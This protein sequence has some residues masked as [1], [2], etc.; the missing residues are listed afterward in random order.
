M[1]SPE[2]EALDPILPVELERSI[3]ETAAR[4]HPASIP[5]LLLVAARVRAWLEP[6]LFQV[7]S[8]HTTDGPKTPLFRS[9]FSRWRNHVRHLGFSGRGPNN[10]PNQKSI[11]TILSMCNETVNLAFFDMFPSYNLHDALKALHLQRL[12]TRLD[13]MFGPKHRNFAHGMFSHLTH[14]DILDFGAQSW[15]TWSGLAQMPHLTHLSFH[16]NYI[17][18]S[19]IHSAL[20]ECPSLTVLVIVFSTQTQLDEFMPHP[21]E[22]ITDPRFVV[23]LVADPLADWEAGAWGGEDYWLRAQ[24]LVEKRCSEGSE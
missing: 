5:T 7:L 15:E 16:D 17:P 13:G 3:F 4:A 18:N 21:R 8:I 19:V 23:L 12:S 6:L 24:R 11:A 20:V 1:S 10:D 2:V 9:P 14:L 22:F